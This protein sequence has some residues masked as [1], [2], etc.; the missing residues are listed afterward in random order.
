M[1]PT[2]QQTG[3]HPLPLAAAIISRLGDWQTAVIFGL[4]QIASAYQA[5]PNRRAF[6]AW[7]D[8]L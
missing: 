4:R 2:S 6:L 1:L 3:Y 7:P 5:G 8:V